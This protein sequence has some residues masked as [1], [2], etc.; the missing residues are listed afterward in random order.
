MS[1]RLLRLVFIL[2]GLACVGSFGKAFYDY[3]QN[4]E[5]LRQ[6]FNIAKWKEGFKPPKVGDVQGHLGSK[7]DYDILHSLDITENRPKVR[8]NSQNT[9]PVLPP[10]VIGEDDLRLLFVQHRAAN[11]KASKAYIQPTDAQATENRAPGDFYAIDEVFQ[12]ENKPGLSIQVL[13][14]RER[15]VDLQVVDKPDTRFTLK[16]PS[17]KVDSPSVRLVSDSESRGIPKPPPP[18]ETRLVRYNEWEVGTEDLDAMAELDEDQVLAQ[19]SVSPFKDAQGRQGLRISKLQKGSV[20]SRQGLKGEDVIL[21]VNGFPAR[22][23]KEVMDWFREQEGTPRFEVEVLRAGR[24]RTLSY[25][26]PSR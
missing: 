19:V 20:F 7:S 4:Q 17:Y 18:R 1:Y 6:G 15:E 9:G 14:I 8:E 13:A 25:R 11:P 21:S 10:P 3:F 2:V 23:R 12:P 22:D 5:Q 26:M 24:V 16:M